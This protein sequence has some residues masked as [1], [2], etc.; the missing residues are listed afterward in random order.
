VT[1]PTTIDALLQRYDGFL[2][3]AY[4]VLVDSS[5]PLP[6]A[7]AFLNRL[8]AEHKPFV[9]LSND[10]SRLPETAA[11]RYRGFGLPIDPDH[12]LTSGSLLA[13][14]FEQQDLTGSHCIVLGPADSRTMVERAGGV[15]VDFDDDRAS[16]F[17][18]CDDAGYDFLPA[19][20]STISTALRRLD[21]GEPVQLLL[22]NPDLTYPKS[23]GEVGLT[24]GSVAMLI[25]AALRVRYGDETPTFIALGKPNPPIFEAGCHRLGLD[26]NRVVMLGDQLGT[27]IQGATGFG[28]DSVL[29]G[30][31]LGRIQPGHTEPTWTLPHLPT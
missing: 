29:V 12:M 11:R 1:A 25:E 9:V 27:D 19:I 3:D 5:G 22:P 2:V 26:R 15:V 13:P 17:I 14:Y 8:Q 31:G 18:A 23:K 10:A 28:V 21:R 30:T 16:V 6:G 4:G 20:E 24:S 7:A